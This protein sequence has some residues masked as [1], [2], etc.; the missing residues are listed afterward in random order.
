MYLLLHSVIKRY[1]YILDA[2]MKKYVYVIM[3]FAI[4]V[5]VWGKP[6]QDSAKAKPKAYIGIDGGLGFTPY[7]S[8][9]NSGWLY[10][11]K[12]GYAI[13]LIGRT[14]LFH[15]GLG[16][17]GKVSFYGNNFDIDK[18]ISYVEP[19]ATTTTTAKSYGAFSQFAI[20]IGPSFMYTRCKLSIEAKAM[21]GI[22]FISLPNSQLDI[23]QPYPEPEYTITNLYTSQLGLGFDGGI[24]FKYRLLSRLQICLNADILMASVHYQQ[25]EYKDYKLGI[26]YTYLWNY[27]ANITMLGLSVGVEYLLK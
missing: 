10:Y 23:K 19:G 5:G 2:G 25:T 24:S 3:L 8:L 27:T 1:L 15:F 22:Y 12:P 21:P 6:V 11:L 4:A 9:L 17:D 20:L 26:D 16:L 18:Y 7:S 13:D 14:P